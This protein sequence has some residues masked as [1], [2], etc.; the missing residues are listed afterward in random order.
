MAGV[1]SRCERCSAVA[2]A[3][4]V[5]A[6]AVAV[7]AA[8]IAVVA[9]APSIDRSFG[10]ISATPLP[11]ISPPCEQP[12][13]IEVTARRGEKPE[14]QPAAKWAKATGV[15]RG[16]AV[17]CACRVLLHMMLSQVVKSCKFLS[18]VH[19]RLGGSGPVAGA[20]RSPPTIVVAPAALVRA[21]DPS[22]P[23]ALL[24]KPKRFDSWCRILSDVLFVLEGVILVG[25]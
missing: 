4:V 8:A 11:R 19:C 24:P 6:V 5:V 9:A 25:Q 12:V 13:Q 3:P 22:N 2:R 23:L 20:S 7:A 18:A 17:S 15:G 21:E 16:T 14:W 10:A 1:P